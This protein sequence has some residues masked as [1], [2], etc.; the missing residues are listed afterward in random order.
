MTPPLKLCQ[1]AQIIKWMWSC[2]QTL[3]GYSSNFMREVIISQIIYRFLQKI[4]FKGWS[5]LN[6]NNLGLVLGMTL[7]F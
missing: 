7:K 2:D 3:V 5:W 1:V 4:D 6:V